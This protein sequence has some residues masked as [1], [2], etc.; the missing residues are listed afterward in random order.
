MGGGIAVLFLGS[1]LVWLFGLL[2]LYTAITLVRPGMFWLF[3]ALL[4]IVLSSVAV[5]LLWWASI[6]FHT[7]WVLG[8]YS[9]AMVILSC[10]AVIVL[11]FRWI[12]RR[13]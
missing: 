3:R 13:S 6:E 1:L 7:G 12:D 5:V 11:L 10:I 9:I 8:S 2:R 4:S